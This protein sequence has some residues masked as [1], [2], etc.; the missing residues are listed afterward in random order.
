MG[1]NTSN[2]LLL[3]IAFIGKSTKGEQRRSPFLFTIIQIFIISI[4]YNRYSYAVKMHTE[5]IHTFETKLVH[6]E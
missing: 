6:V 1:R 4:Q 3:G 5:I 2:E